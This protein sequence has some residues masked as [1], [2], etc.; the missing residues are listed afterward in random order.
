M[1]RAAAAA[2]GSARWRAWFAYLFKFCFCLCCHIKSKLSLFLILLCVCLLFFFCGCRRRRC[3]CYCI[4]SFL[5]FFL[6]AFGFIVCRNMLPYAACGQ[7]SSSSS[8]SFVSFAFYNQPWWWR[9]RRRWWWLRF[10]IFTSFHLFIYFSMVH[11]F[12]TPKNAKSNR[13]PSSWSCS[14][15]ALWF[16]CFFFFFFLYWNLQGAV[17]YIFICSVYFLFFFLNYESHSLWLVWVRVCVCWMEPGE[18]EKF[19]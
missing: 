13:A 7:A 4:S 5:L 1:C 15:T 2:F 19:H 8:S 12:P 16:F 9:W 14:A 10:E 17:I 6:R 18:G 3:G 11:S